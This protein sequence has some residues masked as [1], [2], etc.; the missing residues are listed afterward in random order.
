MPSDTTWMAEGDAAT[1][2]DAYTGASV[3]LGMGEAPSRP[4]PN[5][6]PGASDPDP[7]MVAYCQKVQ[8]QI[9]A[10]KKHWKKQF[11]QMREDARIA[12]EGADAAWVLANQYVVNIILRHVSSKVAV[13]YAKNPAVRVKRRERLMA[14]VWDGSLEQ[15]QAAQMGLPDPMSAMAILGDAQNISLRGH[16]LDTLCKSLELTLTHQIEQQKPLFVEMMKKVVR[17]T[18][19]QGIGYVKLG[20]A[21]E[22]MG[23]EAPVDMLEPGTLSRVFDAQAIAGTIGRITSEMATGDFDE[24][25]AKAAELRLT[26]DGLASAPFQITH[27]GLVFDFPRSTAIIPDR[28]MTSIIGFQGC[29]IVTEEYLLTPEDVSE[30]FGLE[31]EKI[32]KATRYSPSGDTQDAV[33]F[34]SGESGD[35]RLCV[36]QSYHK[37]TGLVTWCLQGHNAFLKPP[38]P[39]TIQLERFWPWFPL[40]FNDCEDEKN[41][42]PPS[43]VYILRHPQ[44]DMNRS[45]QGLREHRIANRPRYIVPDQ[46]VDDEDMENLT[47]AKAHSVVRVKGIGQGQKVEDIV[48][49][50]KPAPIDPALYDTGPQM[51]DIL[52][53]AGS[54]EANLGG[55]TSGTAT[56][57]SIAEN[58]R[59]SSLESNKDDLNSLLSELMGEAGQVLLLY[60]TPESVT[61]IVGE[62]A[63]WPELGAEEIV[64]DIYATIQ[65]GSSGKPNRAAS[66]QNIERVS[67]FLIQMP[68]I[69]P[70]WLARKYL[71]AVDE[72]LDLTEAFAAGVPSITALNNMVGGSGAAPGG[73]TLGAAPGA[74]AEDQGGQ[75]AAN[76][77]QTGS[78]QQGPPKLKRTGG[79]VPTVNGRVEA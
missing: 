33:P 49:A 64:R 31:M 44:K 29:D 46:A 51:D 15:L 19:T 24:N 56:E 36:W 72:D 70:E 62:G 22:V 20:F 43:D 74:R 1:D 18:V 9:E 11:D 48:Q 68:G 23:G 55:M 14:S 71:E 59:I 50:L 8:K 35:Y 3:N 57:A 45:R 52:R 69:N 34:N 42:F 27:E 53:T 16:M 10:N 58:S 17:R 38:A 60:M 2:T 21:R 47:G 66:I 79:S 37:R 65:A 30:M 54:Q 78:E 26:Q 5:M 25:S 12:R 6:D 13:L 7:A 28:T 77:A 4:G 63:V 41:P 61:E 67:P 73:G 40:V 76:G 32:S 39:P 75:G